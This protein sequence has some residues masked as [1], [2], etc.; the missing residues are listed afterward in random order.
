[1]RQTH[2]H[3]DELTQLLTITHASEWTN[4]DPTKQTDGLAYECT[5]KQ[6]DG[7]TIRQTNAQTNERADRQTVTHKEKTNN[8]QDGRTCGQTDSWTDKRTRICQTN[9]QPIRQTNKQ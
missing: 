7:Q 8:G 3:T 4:T 6:T 2:T 1:M 9:K 5:N